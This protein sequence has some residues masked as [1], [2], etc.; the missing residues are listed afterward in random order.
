MNNKRYILVLCLLSL[1]LGA[2]KAQPRLLI[3]K[4]WVGVHG[5]VTASSVDYTPVVEN[6][7]PITKA[8]VLGGN[9]GFVFRYAGHKYCGLQME[10]NYMHRGWAEHNDTIGNYKRNLHYIEVPMMMHLNFGSETCR[11][12]LNAGPQVGYCFKDEGNLGTLVNGEGQAEYYPIK[13]R[14]NWGIVAGTGVYFVTKK[15]GLYQLEVRFDYAFGGIFGTSLTDHFNT[16]SPMDL[17][18][19]LGWLMPVRAKHKVKKEKT[20]EYENKLPSTL[21]VEPDGREEL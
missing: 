17:S 7:T 18:L 21:R 2:T 10:L 9:G 13:N 15:A 1:V 5:G 4:H 16:A 6:M 12:F 20:K 14:F 8:C 3:P 19:N 11:W